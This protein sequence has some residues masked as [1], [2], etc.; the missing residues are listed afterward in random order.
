MDPG[1]GGSAA[2][3]VH[4]GD[5]TFAGDGGEGDGGAGGGEGLFDG[6]DYYGSSNPVAPESLFQRSEAAL[7][8]VWKANPTQSH[9]FTSSLGGVELADDI[10][11]IRFHFDGID[12]LERTVGRSDIT[13]MNLLSLAESVGYG[14]RDKMYYVKE[15]GRGVPRMSLIDGMSKVNEIVQ[16]YEHKQ[17]ISINVSNNNNLEKGKQLI[18]LEDEGPVT[19]NM[20]N[21]DCYGVYSDEEMAEV[22]ESEEQGEEDSDADNYDDK[23][24]DNDDDKGE[25]ND[26]DKGEDNDGKN[27]RMSGLK[28]KKV[29]SM[30]HCVGDTDVEDL[31]PVEDTDSDECIAIYTLKKLPVK[32][33]PTSRSHC[34]SA[35]KCKPDY[36]PSS[37]DNFADGDDSDDVE[38]PF[39]LPR[40][41]T[42]FIRKVD[43][44][45][46]CGPSGEHCKVSCDWVAKNSE[47][48][49]RTDPG[50]RVETV[51]DNAKEKFGVEENRGTGE[52]SSAAAA[53]AASACA[54][55][56]VARP[57]SSAPTPVARPASSAPT[58]VA[59]PD[60]AAANAP[61][62][63][64]A[65]ARPAQPPAKAARAAFIAPR[66]VQS[67]G[68]SATGRPIRAKEKSKRLQ[69]YLTASR[70]AEKSVAELKK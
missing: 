5:P 57:A 17:C 41:R 26:D 29:E 55:P 69:G 47:K 13:F 11:D 36:V 68:S 48:A 31:Y 1:G 9:C 18:V 7:A 43:V 46:T 25:D 65:P 63:T 64:Q 51:I 34:S 8:K 33:G 50:A 20:A 49:L 22:S 32:R 4:G 6:V 60:Q 66:N 40:E 19:V 52:G 16:L 45:H 3:N 28:R 15:E 27:Q 38:L 67:E 44:E 62:P 39:V 2:D 30:R 35:N 70:I 21:A 12:N 24:E 56:P 61:R 42:F 37:D 10:W 54:P 53:S 23:G 58:P 59:R 14:I